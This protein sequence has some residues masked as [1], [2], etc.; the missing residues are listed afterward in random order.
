MPFDLS[1]KS[2]I[3]LFEDYSQTTLNAALLALY[4]SYF[5]TTL[6]RF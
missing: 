2:K 3:Y 4:R 6:T 5:I 1:A